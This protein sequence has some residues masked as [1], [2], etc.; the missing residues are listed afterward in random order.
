MRGRPKIESWRHGAP[1]DWDLHGPAKGSTWSKSP[2]VLLLI[3]IHLQN[4]SIHL[5]F[6]WNPLEIYLQDTPIHPDINAGAL[7]KRPTVLKSLSANTGGD[8][9]RA[10]TDINILIMTKKPWSLLPPPVDFGAALQPDLLA[11]F[12]LWRA[13]QVP[14]A[15]TSQSC[16]GKLKRIANLCLLFSNLRKGRLHYIRP[17]GQSV[18]W[19]VSRSVSPLIFLLQ[20]VWR[21]PILAIL[22]MISK[23]ELILNDVH[24]ADRTTQKTSQSAIVRS[25]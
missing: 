2:K 7:I 9:V 24:R 10:K 8:T 17:V 1:V 5:K 19:S 18:G 21:S 16:G 4:K 11:V 6:T 13:P 14:R 3:E 20:I 23:C 12:F 15:K 25:H 22:K